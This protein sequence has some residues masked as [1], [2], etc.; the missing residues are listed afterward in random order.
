MPQKVRD[1]TPIKNQFDQSSYEFKS[2]PTDSEISQKLQLIDCNQL[3]SFPNHSTQPNRNNDILGIYLGEIGRISDLSYQD[4]LNL[5]AKIK[6]L[7]IQIEEYQKLLTKPNN[8]NGKK[9]R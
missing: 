1:M 8:K 6:K 3:P 7:E 2:I 4:E 5:F 9:H